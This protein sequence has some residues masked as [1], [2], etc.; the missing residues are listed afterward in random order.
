M[1]RNRLQNQEEIRVFGASGG[2]TGSREP[3][4]LEENRFAEREVNLRV[5]TRLCRSAVAGLE[6]IAGASNGFEEMEE[7]KRGRGKDSEAG[8]REL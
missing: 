4:R 6:E 7:G 8:G 5:N 1:S 3:R 2:S